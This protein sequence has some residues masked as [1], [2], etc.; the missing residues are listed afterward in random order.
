MF[1]MIFVLVSVII[2]NWVIQTIVGDHVYQEMSTND[3]KDMIPDQSLQ[4]Y[5]NVLKEKTIDCWIREET[6]CNERIGL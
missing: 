1:I 4:T 3:V 5:F 2:V 6:V